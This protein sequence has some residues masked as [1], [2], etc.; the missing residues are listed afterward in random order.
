[1]IGSA[2]T[3]VIAES[4]TEI[5]KLIKSMIYVH[6]ITWHVPDSRSHM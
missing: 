2:R 5:I 6:E 4:M 3:H 1:M